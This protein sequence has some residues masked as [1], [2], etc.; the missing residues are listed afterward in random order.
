MKFRRR[1]QRENG[2]AEIALFPREANVVLKIVRLMALTGA[3]VAPCLAARAEPMR[4]GLMATLSGP[5]AP[6]GIH[7]RDG[8]LLAVKELGGKLGGVPAEVVVADD[9][10]KPDVAVAKAKSLIDREKV[11]IIAG[12]V[13]SNVMMAIAKPIFESKTFLVSGNAGPSPL[14]GK[15][16]SPYY[17]STSYQN[18]Q[19]HEVMGEYAQGKG[20]KKLILL[21]PNYQAGKD[22]ISGFKRH[23]KGEVV[24]E[25]LTQLGQLDFSAELSKIAAAAPDAVFVFMPGGMGINLVK[26]FR[27]AGLADKIPF[28]SAFTVDETTLPATQDAALGL[29]SG[30]EWAPNIDTPQNKLFVDAYE[31]EYGVPPSLY[32]AQGYDAAKLIDG[33][34][35][36]AGG[37]IADKDALRK[38]FASA[39]FKSVRGEF[40]LNTNG[41][42]IQDFYVVKAAKRADGKFVTEASAKIF[43]SAKDAYA[44]A[45][46]LK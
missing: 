42:P 20:Y 33:A 34:V 39:P 45:C 14:A 32:A 25:I 29:L 44:D 13:F 3:M 40:R 30:A 28:L 19:N 46:P 15:S 7:M 10:L 36:A 17:F 6:L 9:E 21:A 27:Q 23:F 31:K 11:D 18:D 16:C 38:A 5:S 12:V 4:I 22:A 24:D 41:F 26:Q 2:P 37:N 43:Q 35:R 1:I 8:F